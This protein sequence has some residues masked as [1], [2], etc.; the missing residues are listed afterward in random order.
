M[1]VPE[2]M[3]I[4]EGRVDRRQAERSCLRLRQAELDA[5]ERLERR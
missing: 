2:E 1:I 5:E 3:T 4:R